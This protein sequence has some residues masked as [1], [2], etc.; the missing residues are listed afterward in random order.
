MLTSLLIGLLVVILLALTVAPL[1]ALGWWSNKGADEVA[2]TVQQIL[3]DDERNDGPEP[4]QHYLVYLSGIGAIDG[5]SIPPEE[6]PLVE[7]LKALPDTCVV[8]DVFPYSVTNKGLTGQRALSW[9]WR[10]IEKARMKDPEALAGMLVNGRNAAQLFVSSDRRYGPAYNIGTAQE[11]VQALH[12]K[13]YQLDTGKPVTLVGWSGGAQISIGAAWYLG[14]GTIPVRVV[15]IGGMMSD[16]PGL[17]R[18]DHLWHLRGSKDVFEKLGGVMFAG[19][20][21]RAV[22]SP[23][24]DAVKDGRIDIIELGPMHHNGKEHYFDPTT[25]APDGR[26]YL[27]VTIDAVVAVLTGQP[28]KTITR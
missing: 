21:P 18:V 1:D 22:F 13:G 4:Y 26:T 12:R 8:T 10:W 14:M 19:R 16:D 7:A 9:L 27:Q 25:V 17:A 20:W 11:V 15:S 5:H 24:S 6:L 2:A 23:W 28:V 3:V